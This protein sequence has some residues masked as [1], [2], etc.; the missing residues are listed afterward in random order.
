MTQSFAKVALTPKWIGALIFALAL[1]AIFAFL[2]QWQL[3]R[4]ITTTKKVEVSP[5]AVPLTK[6]TAPV[7]PFKTEFKNRI[8]TVDV[9]SSQLKGTVAKRVQTLTDG[10]TQTGYWSVALAS[11]KDGSV[12]TLA[13]NFSTDPAPA[14]PPQAV[15]I[16]G[17]YLPS[18]EPEHPQNGV[19]QSL[20]VE[21]VI[22]QGDTKPAPVYRGFVAITDGHANPISIGAGE[23][24]T[25]VNVLNAFYAV[26]WVLFAGFA[27]FL[28]WRLV[29]DERLGL[30]GER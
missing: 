6:L 19:F 7:E 25:E 1:A 22:N 24:K 10:S 30:R 5:I 2:G 11:L 4:A 26:E 21:Q 3:E 8:V 15:T 9:V 28:W 17:R 20:S 27:V 16:T 14:A 13:Y 12:V 23:T 18:E 29:Q